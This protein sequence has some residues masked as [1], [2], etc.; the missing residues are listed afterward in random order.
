M[1]IKRGINQPPQFVPDTT[2]ILYT[3]PTTATRAVI[4]AVSM[5]ANTA[6]T[7][8]EIFLVPKGESPGSDNI[9]VDKN[10]ALKEPF[11]APQLIG[12][13]LKEGGTIRGN[14]GTGSG[15]QLNIAITVTEFEG[16]S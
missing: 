2:G 6:V 15:A 5:L 7:D 1:T 10:F 14:D 8:V 16:Q 4:T 12:Q 11:T 13:A 9:F 3:V